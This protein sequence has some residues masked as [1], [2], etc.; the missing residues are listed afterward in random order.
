[1]YKDFYKG[2]LIIFIGILL[3][4][5]LAMANKIIL[6]RYLQSHYFGV[7]LLGL[8]VFSLVSVASNL[9]IPGLL[10]KLLTD[11]KTQKQGFRINDLISISMTYCFLFS[12]FLSVLLYF[13]APQISIK[14]FHSTEL[15]SVLKV[16]SSVLPFSIV[17]LVIIAVYRGYQQTILK[18][19]LA[20]LLPSGMCILIFVILFYFGLKLEAAYYAYGLSVM[21][22]FIIALIVMIKN[23]QVRLKPRIYDPEIT[24]KLFKLAWPL[25]IQSF[26]YIIYT[27]ID[28][29]CIG[30]FLTPVEVGIYGA[31][32]SIAALLLFIPQSFSFLALPVFSKLI[33]KRSIDELRKSFNKLAKTMFEISLPLLLCLI[34]LSK[35]ILTILYGKDYVT[36]ATA[37]SILGLGIFSQSILGPAADCLV[38]AGK[39]RE[40]LI[41]TAAGCLINIILNIL[42]IPI[43]G[44]IGAALATC[45]GMIFS[46]LILGYFNYLY[47]RIF[48]FDYKYICWFIICI[49]LTPV[50]V[51]LDKNIHLNILMLKAF[52][53]I[54]IY[55]SL[56]YSLLY[57]LLFTRHGR[58]LRYN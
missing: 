19:I 31:A 9:G 46:R 56:S 45:T 55:L 22:V 49:C 10:P 35:D 30:Y 40:T 6:A 11:Y 17:S 3:G 44:I 1:M 36:G 28:R 39:T 12:V 33:A 48:P 50:I 20:D 47:L 2:S 52:I 4:K 18:V 34:I 58:K 37:L 27:Q 51:F 8:S 38:G 13:F 7:F 5:A 15:S 14:V 29:L 54:S 24:P 57:L 26:V 41:A 16:L 32:W 21:L 42:L 23:T 43:Y 53:L 25:S